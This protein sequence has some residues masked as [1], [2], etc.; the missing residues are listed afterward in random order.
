MES[1]AEGFVGLP[2]SSAVS[3]AL[4]N[5]STPPLQS[6]PRGCIAAFTPFPTKTYLRSFIPKKFENHWAN[7]ICVWK[8]TQLLVKHLIKLSLKKDIEMA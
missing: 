1:P 8:H 7:Y 5:I 3:A 4:T 2:I 6:D